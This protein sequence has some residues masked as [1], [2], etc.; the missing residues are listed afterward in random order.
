MSY[1]G[2]VLDMI[3]RFRESREALNRRRERSKETNRANAGKGG[4]NL[5]SNITLEEYERIGREIKAREQEQQ[6]YFSRMVIMILGIAAV[7]GLLVWVI[8]K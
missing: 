3:I 5:G 6:R 1:G 7:V 8:L 2:H 4:V